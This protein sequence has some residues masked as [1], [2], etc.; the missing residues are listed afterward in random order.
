MPAVGSSKN[1]EAC[2]VCC[3]CAMLPFR[4]AVRGVAPVPTS[5]DYEDIIDEALFLFR[6][7][8]YFANFEIRGP[9]DRLLVVLILYISRCLKDMEKCKTAEEATRTLYLTNAKKMHTPGSPGYALNRLLFP[10]KSEQEKTMYHAYMDQIRIEIS[11][12]LVERVFKEGD[13]S[14]KWWMTF[15]KRDF[16]NLE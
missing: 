8:V 16:M 6:G 15:V 11:R 4:S 1:D 5:P 12:R 2:E 14:R 9:A 10:P 13:W 7:D 3:G